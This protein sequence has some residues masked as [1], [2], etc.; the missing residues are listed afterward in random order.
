MPYSKKKTMRSA[1]DK[2]PFKGQMWLSKL[3]FIEDEQAYEGHGG[4]H[5]AVCCFS[6][7]NYTMY[8]DEL[9]ELPDYAMFGE[10]LTVEHLDESNVYFGNQ[11]QLGEAII[12]VSEIREPC[13]K[14]QAKYDIPNLIKRMSQS[15]KTGFYF[16][17][18]KEG[19]VNDNDNLELI[20]K[21]DNTTLLSVQDLNE[22]YY[23]DRKNLKQINYALQNPYLSPSRL[24]QLHKMKARVETE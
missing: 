19:Y 3:G 12:E 5:K 18:I 14:I 6:K 8:K 11:Y 16:R 17:V 2:S 23:N 7:S 22:L 9:S 15:G 20:K 13:W 10:N 1:L 24:E 4:P 21:A